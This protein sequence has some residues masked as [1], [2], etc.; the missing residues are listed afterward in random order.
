MKSLPM[1]PPWNEPL[2]KATPPADMAIY[3][4]PTGTYETRA[5]FA[6]KGGAFRDE[7]P[8]AA[9]PTLV[10]HPK[11]DLVVDA[12]F[13]S[14]VADHVAS[15]PRYQRPPY[16][17]TQT[18]NEQL[19]ASGYDRKRLLGVLLTHSHWDHVGG[20]DGL[21]VPIWILPSEE[22]YAAEARDGVYRM[23]SPGHQVHEYEFTGPPYLG[24]PSSFDVYGDGS[25]VIV[26]VGG[27]TPGSVVIFVTLPSCKRYAFIGDLSWQLDGIR[28]RVER[29]WLMRMLADSDPGQVRQGLLHMIALADLIQIVPAHDRS[30]YEGIP[31]LPSTLRTAPHQATH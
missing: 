17:A 5:A 12:G 14:N 1:P 30:A 16:T 18:V 3:Q 23:V 9:T 21:Q 2:P 27:H 28:R 26:P 29:P 7:R 4:V 24:F 20:L 13:G 19:D 15:L 8:F 10:M 6:V 31:H 25:V 11:G 22:Q